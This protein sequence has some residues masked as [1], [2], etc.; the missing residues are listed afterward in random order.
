MPPSVQVPSRTEKQ[1]TNWLCQGKVSALDTD[2][3]H[4]KKERIQPAIIPWLAD[5]PVVHLQIR[6]LED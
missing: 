2:N 6:R 4:T 3:G 5:D 1:V